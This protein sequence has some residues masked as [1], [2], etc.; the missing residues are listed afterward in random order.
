MNKRVNNRAGYW[1]KRYLEISKK[2]DEFYSDKDYITYRN[3]LYSDLETI[4]SGLSKSSGLYETLKSINELRL[5][6]GLPSIDSNPAYSDI[7]K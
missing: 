6:N 2:Q 1:E 3:P 5:K 4:Y 7:E